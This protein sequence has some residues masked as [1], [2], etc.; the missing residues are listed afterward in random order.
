MGRE[1]R[2][3]KLLLLDSCWQ[4]ETH[5]YFTRKLSIIQRLDFG[6]RDHCPTFNYSWLLA[7]LTHSCCSRGTLTHRSRVT[8]YVTLAAPQLRMAGAQSRIMQLFCTQLLPRG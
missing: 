1:I 3:E 4:G 5:T 8:G 6:H 2:P 7:C